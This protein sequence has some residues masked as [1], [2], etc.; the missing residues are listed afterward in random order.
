[1][2]DTKKQR[3]MDLG[4]EKLA[5]TLMELAD[6][7][8]L[9]KERMVQLIA[10]PKERL[11]SFKTKLSGIKRSKRFVDW[12]KMQAFTMKIDTMLQDLRDADPKPMEGIALLVDFFE[13]D[14]HIM[15][16]CDDS[17]GDIGDLFRGNA[18][19]LFIE[20]ANLCSEKEHAKIADI[21]LE[22]TLNN[23]Y[24]LRDSLL[25]GASEYL[26]ES[27]VR[28]MIAKLH[29]R[30]NTLEEGYERNKVFR[31]I[32]TFAKQLGDAELYEQ[33]YI[34]CHGS[35]SPY[36]CLQLAEVHLAN[37]EFD[38]ALA[39]VQKSE[40][41]KKPYFAFERDFLLYRIYKEQGNTEKLTEILKKQLASHRTYKNLME[42]L[43]V[44][45]HENKDAI[46]AAEL[47]SIHANEGFEVKDAA[48]LM[49]LKKIDEAE[50][51]VLKRAE[52]IDGYHY[53]ELLLLVKALEASGR[54]LATS[55]LYRSLLNSILKRAQSKAYAHGAKYLK[56]L[57]AL[58]PTVPHWQGFQ[59]HEA[60]K[61]S[62]KNAHGRKT[63]FWA[64]F[65]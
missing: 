18:T 39:C 8:S 13:T 32:E 57:E 45:G 42:L 22:L 60:F 48:F 2:K 53:E 47:T 1:M 29:A 4:A 36:A 21:T 31:H 63:S 34:T 52:L 49:E 7:S 30:A 64:Y 10:T 24:G 25:D 27:T 37:G 15:E 62:I 17:N 50:A 23:D 3:L 61:E 59:T 46:V 38:K 9:V 6:Q 55:I 33:T 14:A 44:V 51:Y 12:H 43:S 58:A 40:E 41:S 35:L 20:Y 56:H 5:D 26:P 28:D 19:D 65:S 11:R 16:I 54:P